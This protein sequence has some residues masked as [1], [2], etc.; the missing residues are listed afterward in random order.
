[1]T[2]S[3]YAVPTMG[4]LKRFYVG[5]GY[6]PSA[7]TKTGEQICMSQDKMISIKVSIDIHTAIKLMKKRYASD[8]QS[9]RLYECLWL[10]IQ[11]KDP[12]LAEQAER[13]GKLRAEIAELL[14]EDD[15]D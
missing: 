7:A 11:E 3:M 13:I 6:I 15:E 1:M 10:F 5:T 9:L 12:E 8:G 14:G 2:D 4:V